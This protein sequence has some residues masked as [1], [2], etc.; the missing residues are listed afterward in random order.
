VRAKDELRI[1]RPLASRTQRQII[2]ILEQ[3]LLLQRT[4]KRL[5][6]RLLGSQDQ[7]QQQPWHKEQNNEKR[8]ENLC[9]DASTSGLD[10][11]KRPGNERK[12]ER[13]EVRNPNCK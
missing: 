10:I 4:L 8:R 6:Q 5:V 7:I 9:E 12:P 3:V 2:K 1:D 13:D 11:A